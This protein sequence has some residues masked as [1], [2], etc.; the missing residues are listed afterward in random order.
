MD[1]TKFLVVEGECEQYDIIMGY[2]FLKKN[3]VV[4]DPSR[5]TMEMKYGGG[6]LEF[7]LGS[8]GEIIGK[9]LYAVDV[10]ANRSVKL[11]SGKVVMVRVG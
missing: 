5:N 1:V 9:R 10:V 2:E 6:C 8:H 4:L 7:T 11:E 3:S